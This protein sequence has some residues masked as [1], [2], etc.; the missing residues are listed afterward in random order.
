MGGKKDDTVG[1][2]PP[3]AYNKRTTL[4]PNPV[5]RGNQKDRDTVGVTGCHQESDEPRTV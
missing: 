3:P 5:S 1:S 4:F 2:D